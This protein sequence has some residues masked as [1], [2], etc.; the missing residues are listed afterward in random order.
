MK[1]V[2]FFDSGIGGLSVLEEALCKFDAKFIFYADRE[3]VPY[4]EKPREEI[5]KYVEEAVDFLAERGA[6]AVV[7]ACNTAT[8]VAAKILRQKYDF[9]II[10]MEPAAKRALDMDSTKRV[11]V[12]ATPVTVAGEKMRALIGRVDKEHLVDLLALPKLVNFAEKGEFTGVKVE[13]YLK[14][15]LAPYNLK[16]YSALVLGCTHFNYFKDTLRNFLPD[17]VSL[18][19]GNEGTVRELARRTGLQPKSLDNE[20]EFYYS[21]RNITDKKELMRLEGYINRLKV[22]REIK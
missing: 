20:V 10:G 1:T 8:S 11:L 5:L 15:K 22:M 12:T 16:D 17:N 14:E 3:N 21:K 19:D 13:T 6:E 2:A 7:L 4:G 9:P 18:V